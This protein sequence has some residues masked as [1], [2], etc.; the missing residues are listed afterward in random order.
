MHTVVANIPVT[1]I[2]INVT[3]VNSSLLADHVEFVKL[4]HPCFSSSEFIYLDFFRLMFYLNISNICKS[5]KDIFIGK[6][7]F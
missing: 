2:S 1:I 6:C 7:Y 5:R 3:L 4:P